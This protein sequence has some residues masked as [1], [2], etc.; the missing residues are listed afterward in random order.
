MDTHEYYCQGCIQQ[1]STDSVEIS[2]YLLLLLLFT[3]NLFCASVGQVC[4]I[5]GRKKYQ[6]PVILH[7]VAHVLLWGAF[8]A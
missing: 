8:F 4:D 6:G 2:G 3:L 1:Y 7:A 5:Y